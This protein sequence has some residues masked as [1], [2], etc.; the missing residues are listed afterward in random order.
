MNR[1]G[2]TQSEAIFSFKKKSH[3]FWQFYSFLYSTLG[4]LCFISRQP[5]L[6]NFNVKNLGDMSRCW[7]DIQGKVTICLGI[8]RLSHGMTFLPQHRWPLDGSILRVTWQ[9]QKQKKSAFQL[10]EG[11]CRTFLA[12]FLF[13]ETQFFLLIYLSWNLCNHLYTTYCECRVG[14]W[15]LYKE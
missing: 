6:L 4:P 9:P 14:V 3:L 13:L 8:P 10:P 5:S 15:W 1:E 7:T 11:P 12:L 2:T